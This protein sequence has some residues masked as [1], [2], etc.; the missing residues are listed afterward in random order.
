MLSSKSYG[1]F[2]SVSGEDR[3]KHFVWNP[4]KREL[5][6]RQEISAKSGPGPLA[7]SVDEK[8]LYAGCRGNRQ[9]AVFRRFYLN[10]TC[11]SPIFVPH[12]KVDLDADPCY[13]KIDSSGHWLL[14][15][16][17]GAGQVTVHGITLNGGLTPDPVERIATGPKAHCIG[18]NSLSSMVWVPHVGQE[19]AIHEFQI[20]EKS[21]RLRSTGVKRAAEDQWVGPVGPRHCTFHKPTRS[22]YFSNEH[23]SSVTHYR[24]NESGLKK[25]MN[26][27]STLPNPYGFANTCAQI[28]GDPAGRFLFVSNRGHN[29]LAIF[30]IDPETGELTPTGWQETE[31]VPRA[32]AITPDSLYLFCTGLD[33]GCLTIYRICSPLGHLRFIARYFVGSSP[34]WVSTTRG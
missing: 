29:S 12:M 11:N 30:T 15:A 9:I 27:L 10:G 32:F 18:I 28:H 23:G 4:A 33:S 25:E 6:C 20:D 16:Y 26:T 7:I 34:M 14:A 5:I 19:N 21:G 31:P 24:F 17:Y 3:I 1:F 8:Y 2:V 22:I 13:L